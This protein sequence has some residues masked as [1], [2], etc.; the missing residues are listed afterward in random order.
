MVV[1]YQIINVL[2]QYGSLDGNKQK[3]K[4]YYQEIYCINFIDRKRIQVILL[5]HFV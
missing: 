5:K 1:K 4:I 3:V 2:Y